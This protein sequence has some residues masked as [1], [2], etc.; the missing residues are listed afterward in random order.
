MSG[1]AR[2][3]RIAMWVLIVAAVPVYVVWLVRAGYLT[4][5]HRLPDSDVIRWALPTLVPAAAVVL[6]VLVGHAWWVSVA[7]RTAS[8][9]R[10]RWTVMVLLFIAAVSVFCGV[11]AVDDPGVS[12]GLLSLV[13]TGLGMAG[14]FFIPAA[15]SRELPDVVRRRF[16][17][18][19]DGPAA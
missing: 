13:V 18:S 17:D 16:A 4:G 3:L 10:E 6:C 19:S 7:T 9:L 15:C 2:V 11:A 8:P 5:Q 14:L 12:A 1:R